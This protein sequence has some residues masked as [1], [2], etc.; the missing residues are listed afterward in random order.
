M[1][2]IYRTVWSETTQSW[3][4]V[5]EAN[6]AKGKKSRS[7]KAGV[8]TAGATVALLNIA[9]TSPDAKADYLL[10]GSWFVSSPTGIACAAVGKTTTFTCQVPGATG[11]FATISVNAA[12]VTSAVSAA[13]TWATSN[14][15]GIVLGDSKTSATGSDS[16]A[17]GNSAK[18]TK[19][20]AIAIGNGAQATGTSTISIGTN[21]NASNVDAIA[22]GTNAKAFGERDIIIGANT[23]GPANGTTPWAAVAIGSDITF[24]ATGAVG[25]LESV[26]V[27]ANSTVSDYG[28]ALG[29]NANASVNGTAVGTMAQAT[30]NGAVAIG[31]GNNTTGTGGTVAS[32]VRSVALGSTSSATAASGVALGA[33]S[34]ASVAGGAAGYNPTGAGASQIAAIQA[35]NSTTLGA[36]SVGTGAA[37][38]NRQIVNLAAGTNDSDA[39]NVAQ[40]KAVS[41][42]AKTTVTAGS[43]NVVVTPTTNADGSSNYK[44]DV[45][46][47]L[48]VN[49]VTSNVVTVGS[50]KIDKTHVDAAG[51]TIISG[52]GAGKVS[53]TSTD[54]INGSQ[55]YALGTGVQNIIG[56]TTTYDP[57]TGTY[58]NNNIGNTGK[59]NIN[60][61][62]ASVNAA[63][64]KAKTTVTAGSNNVVVTPTTNADGSSNYKV[65]VAND[66]NVNSVTSNVVTVGSVKIDKTHV[67]AA[68]N[69]IISGVGAGKVSSTS[70][71]AVN[72]SQL[73]ATNQK[74]TQ[75]T[76][77][78]TNINTTL[79]KGLNFSADSGTTVNRK[80]GDTVAITGDKNI[81]TTT[82][83]NGV[84][85][86]LSDNID[87]NNV[88]VSQSITV[89]EGAKVD[90][91]GNTIQNVGAGVNGTDAVNVNQLNSVA[92]NINN[93]ITTVGNIANAGVAQAIATAG[94]PQ[95]YLPGKNMMAIAGGTY[96][97]EAGY[98]IG[99]STISDNGK[100]II[101]ATG[102]GNSRGKFGASIGAGYQW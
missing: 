29:P 56:G 21:A 92:S 11:G 99:F 5:S 80:L 23:T 41:A 85:I 61:A 100:W 54:A 47:D 45:A 82:T 30:G 8:I 94:L 14:L 101:K 22:F 6:P 34:V 26:A 79:D 18:A 51:N 48:N 84:Q 67:D 60:D 32:G 96:E 1:N 66:L 42:A 83:A 31:S 95:A 50:V 81:V 15:K 38:G 71:D 97:G 88:N 65:D 13:N 102:S 19:D 52:V 78:I 75:N 73:Y 59:N 20:S 57:T 64:T 76:T 16:L 91:G 46:N 35:T 55:L 3:V 93:R 98:A 17:V 7:L 68:G 24:N 87:V 37:G 2:K 40:L 27:G 49:S 33:N 43:N 36:V 53:S 62:I 44:V 86:K 74:V 70:T 77:D 10:D 9:M 39:V 58:V 90:M 4:A 25:R 28:T 63:A 69:T 72:G 12:D 89:A